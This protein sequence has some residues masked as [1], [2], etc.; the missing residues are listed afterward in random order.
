MPRAKLLGG[1]P[2]DLHIRRD[3]R[4]PVKHI[5]VDCRAPGF[6]LHLQPLPCGVHD[7]QITG[8]VDGGFSRFFIAASRIKFQ[9]FRRSMVKPRTQ[10]FRKSLCG[11]FFF[12]VNH[13]PACFLRVPAGKQRHVAL[14][15]FGKNRGDI[16]RQHIA[17]YVRPELQRTVFLRRAQQLFRALGSHCRTVLRSQRFRKF[18]ARFF[19]FAQFKERAPHVQIVGVDPEG[20]V[21]TAVNESDLH[22]YLVEGIGKDTWPKTMNPDVVD[23][24]IRVS[25]RDSFLAARRRPAIWSI[26]P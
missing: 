20:S 9:N 23:D 16:L 24:W 13:R 22:P 10:L 8:Q 11:R 15:A 25:D 14:L 2:V 19:R 12:S 4:R 7:K 17:V 5:R 3:W 6:I 21:Y 18:R 26:R 1:N